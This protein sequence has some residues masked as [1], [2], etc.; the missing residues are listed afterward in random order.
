MNC[1]RSDPFCPW[2]SSG[3]NTGVG[4]SALLPGDLPGQGIELISLTSNLH[5]QVSSLAPPGKPIFYFTRSVSQ[6]RLQHARL[7]CPSPTPRDCSVMSIQSVMP[8]NHLILCCPLLLLPSIFASIRVFSN[9]SVLYISWPKYWSF[10]CSISPS[11]EYSGLISFRID[12]LDLLQSK[13]L[14]KVLYNTSVQKHQFFSSQLSLQSNS[15]ELLKIT[16][17]VCAQ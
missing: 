2:D 11:N 14:S 1:S 7:P 5:W 16:V 9:E 3:K 4:C 12:C 15:R 10:S 17:S 13:G 6:F 8:S